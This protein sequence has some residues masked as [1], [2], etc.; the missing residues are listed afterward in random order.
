VTT[1]TAVSFASLETSNDDAG[2]LMKKIWR[3]ATAQE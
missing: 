2:I 1:L 3:M